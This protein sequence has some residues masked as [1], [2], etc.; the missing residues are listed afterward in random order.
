MCVC[1]C[2][3]MCVSVDA[4]VAQRACGSQRELQVSVPIVT[5][6]EIG[7]FVLAYTSCPLSF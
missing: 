6:F 1:V 3:F 7:S 4:H 2:V 5:L